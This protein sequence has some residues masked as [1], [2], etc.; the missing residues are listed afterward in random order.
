MLLVFL[1]FVGLEFF[2]EDACVVHNVVLEDGLALLQI[3]RQEP[4][5]VIRH[6]LVLIAL[7]WSALDQVVKVERLILECFGVG[8]GL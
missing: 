5:R 6:H 7:H 4:V 2:A 3:H 8:G 1:H